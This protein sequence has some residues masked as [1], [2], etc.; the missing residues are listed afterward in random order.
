MIHRRAWI[1]IATLITA[2]APT[3]DEGPRFEVGDV[4]DGTGGRWVDLSYAYSAE[5]LYW[6][7]A[8][9]FDLR[10]EAHGET[11]AGYFYASYSFS[12]AEHGGTHLD[13]PMH[14]ARGGQATDEIPIE[15]L[16]GPAAVVDVSAKAEP[17]YLVTVDDLTRWESSH[18]RI[19]DGSILLLRTG[20]GERWPDRERYMGTNR[21][22]PDAVAELRFPGLAP[23][24]AEWIVQNRRIAAIGIDTPSIDYGQSSGFESH[25]IIYGAGIPGFENVANLGSLPETGAYVVALPM[26]IEGGSG[27]PLRIVGFVPN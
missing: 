22:G 21:T 8:D 20:W 24:A 15:R 3:A 26:K 9:G 18:G 25:V 11:A 19:P 27:G 2:C 1:G 4:F 14:F 5:T 7:T 10:E 23:G 13:A 6:P 16:I 17:D 12:T